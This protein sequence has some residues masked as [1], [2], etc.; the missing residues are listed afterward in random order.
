M[1]VEL[2]PFEASDIDRIMGWITSRELL[3]LWAGPFVSWPLRRE[4]LEEHLAAAGGEKPKLLIYKAVDADTGEAV[5][6]IELTQI[7]HLNR[8]ARIGRV[9]VGPDRLR[10]QGI[11]Q[12]ITRAVLPIAFEQLGM[13]RV[14]L[15]VFDY[16]KG[17]IACYQ[18]V[19]FKLDGVMRHARWDGKNYINVCVMSML[20]DE[21]RA[22]CT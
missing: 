20:E 4:A 11:G 22:L 16:N 1:A 7:D 8:S 5:G 15:N 18:K 2:R 9:L 3:L 10:G 12:T 13:H 21:W 14:D 6:H 19:G 17:A